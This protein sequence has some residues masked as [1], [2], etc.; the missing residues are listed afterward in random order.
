MKQTP[1]SSGFR[2]QFSFYGGE[3]AKHKATRRQFG[4]LILGSRRMASES[5]VHGNKQDAPRYPRVG[6]DNWKEGK[7]TAVRIRRRI[8]R[9]VDS[10]PVQ[11][12]LG[13]DIRYAARNV[14]PHGLGRAVGRKYRCRRPYWGELA[15]DNRGYGSVAVHRAFLIGICDHRTRERGEIS[16]GEDGA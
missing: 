14:G 11:L 2:V 15:A 9:L 7:L 8:V 10:A 1:I 3:R 5:R 12:P 16:G 4:C 6:R 13:S